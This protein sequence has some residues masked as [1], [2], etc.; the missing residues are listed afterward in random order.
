MA[1][2]VPIIIAGTTRGENVSIERE[3]ITLFVLKF[4]FQSSN[5]DRFKLVTCLGEIIWYSI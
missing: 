1:H 5:S 2:Q 3:Q 4:G